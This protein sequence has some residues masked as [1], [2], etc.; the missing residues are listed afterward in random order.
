MAFFALFLKKEYNK[1]TGSNFPHPLARARTFFVAHTK[2]VSVCQFFL[3]VIQNIVFLCPSFLLFSPTRTQFYSQLK[4]AVTPRKNF[5]MPGHYKKIMPTQQ[6]I[7]ARVLL[8]PYN[9]GSFIQL[10]TLDHFLQCP[11]QRFSSIYCCI[12]TAG[13]GIVVESFSL[14]GFIFKT[15]LAW[16]L[17][18][19]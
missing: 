17:A 12:N 6:P 13:R 2:E 3:S 7:R 10:Q 14:T 18:S 11:C 9:K 5:V 16:K 19:N 8:Q 4:R 1:N 15:T